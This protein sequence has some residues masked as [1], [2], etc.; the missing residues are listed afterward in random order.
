LAMWLNI[1]LSMVRFIL[2][3][4]F[5]T[6]RM[7][8]WPKYYANCRLLVWERNM[9]C[10][11]T[12][13]FLLRSRISRRIL[14]TLLLERERDLRLLL[15]GTDAD[16]FQVDARKKPSHLSRWG[17]FFYF[18]RKYTQLYIKSL[19]IILRDFHVLIF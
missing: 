8:T 13:I 10:L 2:W 11:Q 5:R 9:F 19:R 1:S 18:W 14:R 3:A 15:W 4:R 6:M 12:R 17:G 7:T 16:N